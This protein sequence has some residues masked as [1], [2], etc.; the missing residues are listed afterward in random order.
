MSDLDLFNTFIDLHENLS[1]RGISIIL[2]G[3][4]GL[5]LK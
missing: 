5:Y 1:G 3:G 4:L 2:G